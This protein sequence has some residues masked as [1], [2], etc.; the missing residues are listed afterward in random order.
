MS[1]QLYAVPNVSVVPQL[2]GGGFGAPAEYSVGANVL[3]SGIGVGDVT[4]DGRNDVVASYGGNQPN[5]NVAVFAQ[6][7]AGTL[8]PPASSPSYDIP[9]PVEVADV[10]LD[11]RADVVTLHGGWNRAGLYRQTVAGGLAAEE[12]YAIPYASHYEAHGL[13]LGDLDG[14]GSPDLARGRRDRNGP[15]LRRRTEQGSGHRLRDRRRCGRRPESRERQREPLDHR[16]L[17]G[18]LLPRRGVRERAGCADTARDSCR[19][20]RRTACGVCGASQRIRA[21]ACSR[22][23]R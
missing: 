17:S 7:D 16:A 9:E 14:N 12:L 8:A 18:A 22:W 13:A 11:G 23:S 15:Y 2:A 21:R 20:G 10:D 1:G 3:T 4:G 19:Y 6:T 5:S